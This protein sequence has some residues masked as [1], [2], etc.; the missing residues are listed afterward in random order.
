MMPD[1][2]LLAPPRISSST[3]LWLL[4][5]RKANNL[6]K[7]YYGVHLSHYVLTMPIVSIS[8]RLFIT[9]FYYL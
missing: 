8:T 5:I 1:R 4:V 3:C 9:S 6:S 2:L 7:L